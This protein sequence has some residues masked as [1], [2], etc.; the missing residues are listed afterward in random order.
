MPEAWIWIL[1]QTPTAR[2][3]WRTQTR[4][5]ME[6]GQEPGF[7]RREHQHQVITHPP[8]KREEPR[9]RH[10]DPARGGPTRKGTHTP[11]RGRRNTLT[12]AISS[13]GSSKSA[14]T[15]TTPT[16]QGVPRG[17]SDRQDPNINTGKAHH[18]DKPRDWRSSNA[19]YTRR[20]QSPRVLH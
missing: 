15:L 5:N 1:Q 18:P 10:R 3:E 7:H 11:G 16:T 6:P 8:D 13:N 9:L 17:L 14:D 20:R 19:V 12:I 4:L 2:T